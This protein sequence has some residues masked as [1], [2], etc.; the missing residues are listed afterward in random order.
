MHAAMAKYE[1]DTRNVM[2]TWLDRLDTLKGAP[3]E[4]T[5]AVLL[6]AFD[7]MGKIGF[8]R[9]F[10]TIATGKGVKWLDLL[11][12]LLGA[13]AKLG[14]APWPIMIAKSIGTLGTIQEFANIS[15]SMAEDRMKVRTKP[16]T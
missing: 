1:L 12:A 4:I 15:A 13:V 9:E 5:E 7:N 6:V 3:V 2:R 16:G 10:G 14:G 11:D 8:S